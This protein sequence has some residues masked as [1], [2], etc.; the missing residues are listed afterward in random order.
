MVFLIRA[1]C[2]EAARR[3][4]FVLASPPA[5]PAAFDAGLARRGEGVDALIHLGGA[6]DA[7]LDRYSRAVIEVRT[8]EVDD[9]LSALREALVSSG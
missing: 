1:G 2:G 9:V 5:D 8:T 7:L 6:P 3:G 4:G